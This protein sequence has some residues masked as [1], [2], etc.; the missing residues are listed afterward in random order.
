MLALCKEPECDH[1]SRMNASKIFRTF[2]VLKELLPHDDNIE[3]K[4]FEI[5]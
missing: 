5:K 3:R 1:F 4:V 2:G